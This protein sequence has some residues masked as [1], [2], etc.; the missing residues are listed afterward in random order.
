M[1]TTLKY[2]ALLIISGVIIPLCQHPGVTAPMP[3]SNPLKTITAN[4]PAQQNGNSFH[5][6]FLHDIAAKLLPIGDFF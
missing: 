4:T 5:F 3:V 1:K 2:I 6:Y